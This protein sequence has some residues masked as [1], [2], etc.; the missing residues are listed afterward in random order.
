LGRGLRWSQLGLELGQS[1]LLSGAPESVAAD[2]NKAFG[3][4]VLEEAGD[5]VLG[6][7]GYV[8]QVLGPVIPIAKGNLGV[9]E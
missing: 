8:T 6:R 1:L 3:Q 2:F 4:D 9:V 5:E 7:E